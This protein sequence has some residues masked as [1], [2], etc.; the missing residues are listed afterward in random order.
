M[1]SENL[2]FA[3]TMVKLAALAG[4]SAPIC[5]GLAR[6]AARRW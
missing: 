3:L 2:Y 5:I 6:L 1:N 4:V